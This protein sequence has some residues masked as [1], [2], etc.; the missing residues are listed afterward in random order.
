MGDIGFRCLRAVSSGVYDIVIT[1]QGRE[2][3]LTWFRDWSRPRPD[4][5]NVLTVLALDNALVQMPYEAWREHDNLPN[6]SVSQQM[7]T[8]QQELWRRMLALFGDDYPLLR[9]SYSDC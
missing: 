2:M 8:R 4:L 3:R 7:Y 5:R 9:N 6:D 1:Y